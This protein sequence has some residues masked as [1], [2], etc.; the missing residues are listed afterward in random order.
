[1]K[2][3]KNAV[4][5]IAADLIQLFSFSLS[6]NGCPN[7]MNKEVSISNFETYFHFSLCF[8]VCVLSRYALKRFQDWGAHHKQNSENR[9]S[10]KRVS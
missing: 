2:E 4:K 1:M 3:I 7:A 9:K 6:S 8:S 5:T 10:F